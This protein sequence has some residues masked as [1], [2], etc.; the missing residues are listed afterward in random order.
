MSLFHTVADRRHTAKS[1]FVPCQYAQSQLP[2]AVR[3]MPTTNPDIPIEA[4]LSCPPP[5][6][7]FR[8][9]SV[10]HE[11]MVQVAEKSCMG[12]GRGRGHQTHHNLGPDL[13]DG[14]GPLPIRPPFRVPN[15]Y[16]E[17]AA[18]LQNIQASTSRS[19]LSLCR[20][21]RKVSHLAPCVDISG[22]GMCMIHYIATHPQGC[23]FL[24]LQ[25]R[26]TK[27]HES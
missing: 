10:K 3:S 13:I 16:V 2:S 18:S 27:P 1:P 8:H 12:E 17:R 4:T 14:F 25:V 23:R 15:L 19:K 24:E 20:I 21:L 5:S 11:M 7:D 22:F 9:C 6:W 26:K